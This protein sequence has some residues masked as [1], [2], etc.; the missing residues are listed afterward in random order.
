MNHSIEE[1]LLPILR[2]FPLGL[3]PST[4]FDETFLHSLQEPALLFFSTISIA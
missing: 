1:K 4:N 3:E 2:P